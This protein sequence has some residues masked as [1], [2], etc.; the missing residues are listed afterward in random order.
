M[1]S[2]SPEVSAAA[3]ALGSIG[4]H[5]KWSRI[6]Q[7]QRG[8]ATQPA[9]D[10]FEQRFLDEADGDPVRAANLRKAYFKRLALKSA[11]ARRQR[12]A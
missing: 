11:E 5:I 8:A 7:S 6:P 12:S 3:A 10:A 1:R 2:S 4:G 9:R